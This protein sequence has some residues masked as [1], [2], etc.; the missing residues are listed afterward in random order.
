MIVVISGDRFVVMKIKSVDAHAQR[1]SKAFSPCRTAGDENAY[2]KDNV[3]LHA[4]FSTMGVNTLILQRP[5]EVRAGDPRR[6]RARCSILVR[7]SLRCGIDQDSL[8][9]LVERDKC[10]E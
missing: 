8:D 10:R 3:A 6:Y 2:E 5:C 4:S 7:S 1:D 9:F